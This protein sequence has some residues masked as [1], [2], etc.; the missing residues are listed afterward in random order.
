[1][2]AEAAE[3]RPERY[4][5]YLLVL[6]RTQLHAGNSLRNKLSA[7]DLVQE[8]LLKAH[9][10]LSQFQG[11]TE[12]ELMGWLRSILAS[13]MADAARHF[14]RK[15]RN[16]GLEESLRRSLDDSSDQMSRL[17]GNDTSPSQHTL[18]NERAV[19][20][21]EALTA[22]PQDQATAIKLRYLRG[23]S[24]QEVAAA[25]DR[26]EAA[27]AGLLRRGLKDL[28]ERLRTLE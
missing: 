8:A 11:T 16:A 1:M 21:S 2:P 3:L 4:R 13:K 18:R 14:F 17:A 25:M 9:E 6:A 22:L 23:S 10:S 27:V 12:A 7:S 24:V 20:L 28:R 26:T 5:N 15:K 19:I